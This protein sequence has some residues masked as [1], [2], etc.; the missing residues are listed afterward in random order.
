ML[1]LKILLALV[2]WIVIIAAALSLDYDYH[3]MLAVVWAGAYAVILSALTYVRAYFRA[4]QNLRLESYS[5][6]VE[7]IVVVSFGAALRGTAN[8]GAKSILLA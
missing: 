4:F 5:L 3:Q 6:V 7:K 2:A 8:C 1:S